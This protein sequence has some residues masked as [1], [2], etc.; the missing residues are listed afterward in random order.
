[1]N[2]FNLKGQ[3]KRY[4]IT[5]FDIFIFNLSYWIS[6]NIRDEIFIIPNFN[7]IIHLLIGNFIFL[8]LY[9]IFQIN[10]FV[11]RYFDYVYIKQF[12]KFLSIF[13][14]AYF[15][16]TIFYQIET[17]PRSSPI[18]T[19]VVLFFIVIV[20]RFLVVTLLNARVDGL[21]IPSIIIGD[22]D[23]IYN[24][25]N[26]ANFRNELE[27]LGLFSINKNFIGRK[28]LNINVY[29]LSK[30]E[31]FLTNNKIK[32]AIIVSN[33]FSIIKIRKLIKLLKRYD[34]EVFDYNAN[35]E[36]KFLEP[37]SRSKD[38]ISFRQIKFFFQKNSKEFNNSSILITGAGG[39]IG[40][41][42]SKQLIKF[43]PKKIILVEISEIN[44]FNINYQLEKLKIKNVK[45]ISILGNINNISFLENIF[46][47]Y[48]PNLVYHAAAIKHVTIAENNPTECVR[49]NII[50]SKNVMELS[51][52]YLV[53]KFILISTDKAVNPVNIMGS[54]KR[55]AEIMLKYNQNSK[56]NTIFSAVRFGNVANSSGSVFPIW[57]DQIEKTRKI[58]IT[59]PNATRY[60][61]SI[62]EAVSLVLDASILAKK[63]KIFVLDMGKPIRII[64]LAKFFLKNS[65]Y[66]LKTSQNPSGQISYTT[67]GLR[68]G[69]KKH[70][71]LFYNKN[72]AKTLN[73]YVFD[74]NEKFSI[75]K[76]KIIEFLNRL[77]NILK[78][79]NDID[80]KKF[81]TES[82]KKLCNS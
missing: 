19:A 22:E 35:S 74:S 52:K 29:S 8:I 34:V 39:S 48:K 71:E 68:P 49:T 36:N 37:L 40:S 66:T 56:T 45:I 28:I 63:G 69:E 41:E 18:L 61:M 72:F 44:L 4:I 24:F 26:L 70:E 79:N 3:Y 17:V 42:L 16:I 9:I 6:Y 38:K 59:D 77:Q 75:N 1:M 57:K 27:I 60:L 64:E 23:K 11:T 15:A 62:K 58:T 13:A 33:Q 81:I 21:K 76:K 50:G 25:H 7:Q 80:C 53:K 30:I 54:S 55:I 73:P 43:K 78:K 14:I 67:I 32:K 10:R 65:G 2:L 46:K 31:V 5:L 47:K 20:S 51:N 82:V 12:V